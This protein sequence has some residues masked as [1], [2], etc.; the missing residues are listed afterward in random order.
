[1]CYMYPG[2]PWPIQ[3]AQDVCRGC[4][5]CLQCGQYRGPQ[6]RP[7]DTTSGGTTAQPNVPSG[8]VTI[9]GTAQPGLMAYQTVAA[10]STLA[11]E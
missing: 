4:G 3:S 1:M 6:A 9:A 10:S 8:T 7:W 2:Y 11:K 5:Y